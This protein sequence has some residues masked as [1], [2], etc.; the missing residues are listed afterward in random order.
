MTAVWGSAPTGTH[1]KMRGKNAFG[2]DTRAYLHSDQEHYAC[3]C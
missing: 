1:F 3:Y 2:R